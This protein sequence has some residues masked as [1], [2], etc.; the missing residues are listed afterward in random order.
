[1]VV[2]VEVDVVD[3]VSSHTVIP[4]KE[5]DLCTGGA[6]GTRTRTEKVTR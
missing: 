5:F 2:E 4:C 6:Q 3:G 1:M